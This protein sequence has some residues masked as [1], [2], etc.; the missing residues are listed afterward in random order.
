MRGL[1]TNKPFDSF[2]DN[3]DVLLG[4]I[5]SLNYSVK[6][7]DFLQG[8]NN[9]WNANINPDYLIDFELLNIIF[10]ANESICSPILSYSKNDK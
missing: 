4:V 10:M 1:I 7:Y 2:L 5:C 3:K 6:L 9:K 8:I